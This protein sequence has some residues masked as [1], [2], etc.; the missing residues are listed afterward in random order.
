MRLAY[1]LGNFWVGVK[2]EINNC[3]EEIKIVEQRGQN[4]SDEDEYKLHDKIVLIKK[5]IDVDKDG[6]FIE[7]GSVDSGRKYHV[8][9]WGVRG[10][11][12]ILSNGRVI[13]VRP[14]R[15]GKERNKPE[16]YKEKQYIFENEKLDKDINK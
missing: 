8:L 1:W 9:A 10:H 2:Y 11:E 7:Y 15:K 6:R 13:H 16:A 3:P 5:I 4:F 14:Y 12:R